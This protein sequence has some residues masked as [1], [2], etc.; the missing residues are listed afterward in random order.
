MSTESA[1]T[2]IFRLPGL[3]PLGIAESSEVSAGHWIERGPSK[4][5]MVFS[6]RSHPHLAAAIAAKL[7]V[8]L[9]ETA[10]E[11]FPHGETYCRDCASVRGS[12][13]FLVQTGGDPV[14]RN[15]VG[16]CRV[17]SAA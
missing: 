4:R 16:L 5:L 11:T 6:G 10:L 9:G 3:E 14:V 12:G 2:E 15:L 13:L 17:L 8:G 1:T 7:G